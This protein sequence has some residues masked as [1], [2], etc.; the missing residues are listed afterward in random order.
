MLETSQEQI[1][2]LEKEVKSL[3]EEIW[4]KERDAER[5]LIELRVEMTVP[6]T[7]SKMTDSLKLNAFED[8]L[9]EVKRFN[10]E[11]LSNKY[12]VITQYDK[13]RKTLKN[14]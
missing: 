5:R 10:A 12:D 11:T 14:P 6:V 13:Y 8:E 3:Q 4:I 1:V 2:I 9:W 7:E